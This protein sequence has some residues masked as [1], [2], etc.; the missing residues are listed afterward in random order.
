MQASK[1]T[2]VLWVSLSLMAALLAFEPKSSAAEEN[3]IRLQWAFGAL[4]GPEDDPALVSIEETAV[5]RSGDR[6]KIFFQPQTD[7]HLYLFYQSSQA[8]L[9]V[10]LPERG[11]GSRTTAGTRM[12]VPHGSDWFRLDEITG[13]ETFYL[14]VSARPL[15]NIEA[16]CNNLSAASVASEREAVGRQILSEI[17]RLQKYRRT[18]TADAERPIRLGG[19]FR[20]LTEQGQPELPD[21]SKIAMEISAP[22][23]YSRTFTIDHR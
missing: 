8:E 17:H 2:A 1:T 5:L 21:I 3:K 12:M 4:T 14:L 6:M 10:L 22:D 20:G 7:C 11:S 15:E 9:M 19:N 18:L 23:F 16:L 13:I